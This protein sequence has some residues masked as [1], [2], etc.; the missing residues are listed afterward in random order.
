MAAYYTVNINKINYRTFMITKKKQ[1]NLYKYTR[2][3][4]KK[5]Y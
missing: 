3:L 1:K 5:I 2:I 4:E